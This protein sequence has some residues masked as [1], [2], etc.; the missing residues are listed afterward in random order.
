MRTL[1]ASTLIL[2]TL[3]LGAC[4]GGGGGYEPPTETPTGNAVPPTATAS[5]AS[6]VGYV[7]TLLPIDST[8]PLDIQQ[9]TPPT[10]ENDEPL[11]VT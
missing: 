8:E 9:V 1:H 6:F 4:G 5:I 2:A 11:P 7:G 10:T 3:A